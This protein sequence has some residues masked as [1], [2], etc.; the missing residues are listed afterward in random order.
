M[1]AERAIFEDEIRRSVVVDKLTDVAALMAE[2]AEA[3]QVFLTAIHGVA[4]AT[5]TRAIL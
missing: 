1:E 2:R 5:P 3:S 4:A